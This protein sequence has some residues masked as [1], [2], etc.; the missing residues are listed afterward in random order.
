MPAAAGLIEAMAEAKTAYFDPQ[1]LALRD[2]LLNALV[3]G[4]KPEMTANQ[5]SPIRSGAWLP[6]LAS[7]N[8]RSTRQGYT[9]AQHS[10]PNVHWR[11]NCAAGIGARVDL[12]HHDGRH[13]AASSSRCTRFATPC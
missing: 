1:Y 10:R 7:P 9:T 8:A 5:W 11:C 2:R 13:A 4:E 6:R 12:R 3:T